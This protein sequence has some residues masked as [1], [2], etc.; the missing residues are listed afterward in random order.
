MIQKENLEYQN[1]D[2][3]KLNAYQT[4]SESRPFCWSAVIFLPKQ[5]LVVVTFNSVITIRCSLGNQAVR[6][7]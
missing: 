5:R 1:E 3:D 4:P 6:G 2:E 7:H